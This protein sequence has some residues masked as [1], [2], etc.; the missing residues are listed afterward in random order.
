MLA[1]LWLPILIIPYAV[2]LSPSVSEALRNRF[3]D[4]TA[5]RIVLI[6]IL[7]GIVA[8]ATWTAKVLRHRVSSWPAGEGN[9]P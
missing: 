1:L 7:T 2:T 9:P 8:V 3:N 5:R 6:P 4:D